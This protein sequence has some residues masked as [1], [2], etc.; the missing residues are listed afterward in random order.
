MLKKFICKNFKS[1]KDEI[2]FD[3]TKKKE[4]TFNTDMIENGIVNKGLIYGINGCGKTNLGLALMDITLHLR[5]SQINPFAKTANYSFYLNAD[6]IE[7]YASFTYIFDF[8]GIEVEYRYGKDT[9]LVL[10]FEELYV[11]GKL[12]MKYDHESKKH[13]CS[14]EEVNEEIWNNLPSGISALKYMRN[15]SS[16]ATDAPINKV[17]NFVDNMLWFRSLRANEFIGTFNE[18]DSIDRFIIDNGYLNDFEVFLRKCGFDLRLAVIKN[19]FT[20]GMLLPT[21][22]IG[23]QHKNGLLPFFNTVSTGTAVLS[24]FYYWM[25]KCGKQIKFLFI[26]EFDAFYHSD[27]SIEVLKYVLNIN[28]F[29]SFLTT[30][31]S[32]LAD[33][34]FIRP[35]CY[36]LMKNG[37]IKSFADSTNKIIREGNSIEHM[38]LS[39]E[40]GK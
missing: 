15:N 5:D 29:Q 40:F 37:E 20:N 6:S 24:L 17:L 27:L 9:N 16:F 36:F 31:N 14:F 38:L 32:R 35:D 23:V 19:V 26:D 10:V 12:K 30:H 21:N 2:I 39:G 4:Y 8:D 13:D 33:N 7:K 25:K 3:L 28:Y 18:S 34:A 11:D 1:F 22:L